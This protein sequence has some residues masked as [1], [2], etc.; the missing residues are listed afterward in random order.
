MNSV[1]TLDPVYIST[2]LCNYPVITN[3]IF[4]KKY[5]MTLIKVMH[6]WDVFTIIRILFI[7]N[8]N[9]YNLIHTPF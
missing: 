4:S 8:L 3:I 1:I 5:I 9:Y 7:I 6:L 2:L